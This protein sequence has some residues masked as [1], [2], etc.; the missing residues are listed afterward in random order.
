MN[1]KP[2]FKHHRGIKRELEVRFWEKV[3]VVADLRGLLELD[4]SFG[5]V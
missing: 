2:N 4:W 1:P 3:N 5:E